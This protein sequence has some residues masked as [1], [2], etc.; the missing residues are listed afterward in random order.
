MALRNYIF[1]F[2][3][4]FMVFF[5]FG[6]FSSYHNITISYTDDININTCKSVF[7]TIPY[8]YW[9]G[10]KAL[11]IRD[12]KTRYYGF[13]FSGSRIIY[14]N[15]GCEQYVIIHE[16]AHH[17]QFVKKESLYNIPIH[18]GNFSEYDS[19]ITVASSY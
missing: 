3:S 8:K 6:L 5:N 13:Y 2:L 12:V 10:V 18:Q 4:L 19:E 14:L 11:S 1:M 15:S 9:E 16:L 7:D 17:R